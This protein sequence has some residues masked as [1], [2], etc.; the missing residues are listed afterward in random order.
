[1]KK[2]NNLSPHQKA[3]VAVAVL[4]DGREAI[5]YLLGNRPED[6]LLRQAAEE[7][8]NLQPE[9]RMPFIGTILRTAIK[10]LAR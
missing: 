9:L 1:M 7:I 2:F 6:I 4:L 3:L 5:A 10:E 8:S